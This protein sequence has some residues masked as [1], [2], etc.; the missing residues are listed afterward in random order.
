MA[1]IEGYSVLTAVF[2]N[3]ERTTIR[4]TLKEDGSD[5]IIDHY[6]T[7]DTDVINH[8]FDELLKEMTIDE[9]H[10]A[11]FKE[12]RFQQRELKR[13]ALEVAKRNGWITSDVEVED[14]IGEKYAHLKPEDA[15]AGDIAAEVAAAQIP[16]DEVIIKTVFD[17]ESNQDFL[18]QLK[19][20]LF[21]Q[22][23][24]KDC[25]DRELKRELRKA[26]TIPAVMAQAAAIWEIARTTPKD[27]SED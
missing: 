14:D 3:N 18:F 9:I 15:T 16:A 20:K 8:D 1:I 23:W 5:K 12:I 11:T 13:V 2:T 17:F 24:V 26:E 22:D 21:E 4:A 7:A 27:V 6:L 10:E 25:E 19:L